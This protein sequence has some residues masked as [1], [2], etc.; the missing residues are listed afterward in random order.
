MIFKMNMKV[1]INEN[2]QYHSLFFITH[3]VTYTLVSKKQ[4]KV[5]QSTASSLLPHWKFI[6]KR[7]N[8]MGKIKM[9]FYLILLLHYH[10]C[11]GWRQGSKNID[12]SYYT[13]LLIPHLLTLSFRT[14]TRVSIN[15]GICEVEK[16]P[17]KVQQHL[18]ISRLSHPHAPILCKPIFHWIL[19]SQCSSLDLG[20]YSSSIWLDINQC[21]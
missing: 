21:G 7:Y 17:Y 18:P 5:Y 3:I 11:I 14:V 10:S 1:K 20:V 15:L 6:R 9:N 13:L 8:L 19:C 16:N 2:K 12:K 4:T